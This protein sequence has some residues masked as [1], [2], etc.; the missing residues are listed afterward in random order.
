MAVYLIDTDVLIDAI[1][2]KKE[3]WDLLRRL[4]AGGGSL[5]C[6]VVTIG[7][8]YAGMR[9]HEKAR[10][11]ELLAEFQRYEVTSE[12]AR[13]AGLLKNDWSAQGYTFSLPDMMI[14]ATAIAH[15]VILVTANAKDF[16]MRELQVY[17]L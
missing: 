13:Y 6:S 15:K 1:R 17:R 9:A 8:L 5:A 14:A 16:P 4:V 11:E 10:T 7:E 3:R 12:I 2:Q